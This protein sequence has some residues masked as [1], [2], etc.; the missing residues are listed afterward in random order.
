MSGKCAQRPEQAAGPAH[1][2]SEIDGVAITD[3]VPKVNSQPMRSYQE[4][5]Q[6][7]RAMSLANPLWCG[8]IL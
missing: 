1:S 3:D 4:R 5:R 8:S 7:I 6:L 2:C